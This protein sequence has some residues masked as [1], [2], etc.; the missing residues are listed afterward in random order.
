MNLK[1][2]FCFLTLAL[3]GAHHGCTQT[4][5]DLGICSSFCQTASQCEWGDSSQIDDTPGDFERNQCMVKCAF[6]LSSGAYVVRRSTACEE[7]DDEAGVCW[8]QVEQEEFLGNVGGAAVERYL[9]CLVDLDTW[10]CNSGQYEMVIGSAEE[11]SSY[12]ECIDALGDHYIPT[13]EWNNE[14]CV[15]Q[16]EADEILYLDIVL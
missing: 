13:P 8:K 7:Y 11:C 4:E 14:Q 5:E 10:E 12:A 15:S 16:E 9:E 2:L 1:H 6:Y 3:L